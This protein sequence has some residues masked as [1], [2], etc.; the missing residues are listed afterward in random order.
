VD[1]VFGIRRLLAATAATAALVAVNRFEPCRDRGFAGG[2]LLQDAGGVV[3]VAN[4]EAFSIV[5]AA[6]LYIL[7]GRKRG[8]QEHVEAQEL[9]LTLRQA[10]IRFSPARQEALELLSRSG[11]EFNGFDLSGTGLDQLR[12]PGARWHGVN[13]SGSTLRQADLRHVDLS[14]ADLPGA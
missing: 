12:I 11:L 9:L 4:L 5:T 8:Q 13:L 10:G 1:H 7:E 2:C 3:T 14:Q 6:F